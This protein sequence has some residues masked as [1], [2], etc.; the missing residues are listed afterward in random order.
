VRPLLRALA[1][2]QSW[3]KPLARRIYAEARA[4]YHPLVTRDLDKLGL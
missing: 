3:G 2:D 4:L 1:K